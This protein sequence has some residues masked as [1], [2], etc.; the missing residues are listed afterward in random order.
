[1]Q[2][3]C[4]ETRCYAVRTNV[5][6]RTIHR[7]EPLSVDTFPDVLSVG[8]A[9]ITDSVSEVSFQDQGFGPLGFPASES[10]IRPICSTTL[11]RLD[12]ASVL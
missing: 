6:R 9:P 12:G 11:V 3:C 7:L 2:R 5:D 1:M 4:F 10:V 8:H